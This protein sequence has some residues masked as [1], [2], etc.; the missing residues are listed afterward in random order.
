MRCSNWL[1]QSGPIWSWDG[2]YPSGNRGCCQD[3][4]KGLGAKEKK[5]KSESINHSV[6]SDSLRLH[7]LQSARLL[8]P[9]NSAGKNNG[10]GSQFPSLGNLLDPG[11]EPGSSALQADSLSSQPPGKPQGCQGGPPFPPP[12]GSVCYYRTLENNR[13]GPSPCPSVPAAEPS[14]DCVL[15]QRGSG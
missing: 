1:N 7:G 6:V 2:V 5:V 3:G 10:V 4:G 9:W 14:R 12:P 8:F 13:Q 15:C 11:M